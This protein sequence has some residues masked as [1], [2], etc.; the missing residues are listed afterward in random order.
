[1]TYRTL[2]TSNP[3]YLQ[4][5]LFR[6]Q[7]S[8]LRSSSTIQL[9]QPVHKSSLINILVCLSCCLE[10]LTSPSKSSTI[11]GALQTSPEDPPLQDT[12]TKLTKTQ[13]ASDAMQMVHYKLTIIIIINILKIRNLSF[14]CSSLLQD[15][16]FLITI[17]PTAD[18]LRISQK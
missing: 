1:M 12:N 11:P 15:S 14:E 5:L 8:G 4:H 17:H 18:N 9:H 2:V 6:R 7:T 16:C 10:C 3:P 13:G